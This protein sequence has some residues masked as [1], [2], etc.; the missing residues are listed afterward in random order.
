VCRCLWS[1]LSH[2]PLGIF[3]GVGLVDHT[4]DLCLVFLRNLHIVFQSGCTSLHSYQQCMRVP[5]S[6]HPYQHLLLVVFL[7]IVILTGVRWNLSV[8]LIYISFM[9]RDHEHFFM[10]F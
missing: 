3:L 9:A 2:I 1:N 10:C 4:A 6:S 8:V 7:M 5:F